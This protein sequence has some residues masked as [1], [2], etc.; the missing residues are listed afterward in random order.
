LA[1]FDDVYPC[2][3]ARCT[4]L[5]S[6]GW[7]LW[8]EAP[9]L[10]EAHS[11]NRATG[12]RTGT[13]RKVFKPAIVQAAKAD[14]VSRMRSGTILLREKKLR[15][16]QART[17]V[18]IRVVKSKQRQDAQNT[19]DLTC[20]AIA[21]ALDVDDRWFDVR[22]SWVMFPAM[23]SL[24]IAVAQFVE[25]DCAVCSSCGVELPAEQMKRSGRCSPCH[26]WWSSA[27]RAKLKRQRA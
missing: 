25:H 19:I 18:S 3:P 14:I 12:I 4:K 26:T 22:A 24:Q 17:S 11:K 21:E 6:G 5:N 2:Q 27:K 23:S 8:F 10:A 16:S 20:D 7:V 1:V 13:G 9:Y 15:V